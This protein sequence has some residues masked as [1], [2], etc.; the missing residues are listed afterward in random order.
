MH[1]FLCY[2]YSIYHQPSIFLASWILHKE[3]S[4][5]GHTATFCIKNLIYLFSYFSSMTF[6]FTKKS[7][8][9]NSACLHHQLKNIQGTGLCP[10]VKTQKPMYSSSVPFALHLIQNSLYVNKWPPPI[11]S[12]TLQSCYSVVTVK[13][14]FIFR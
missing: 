13:V 3:M 6:L 2:W 8:Y 10:L 4:K 1:L 11:L 14:I 12:L 7:C 5:I 9:Q